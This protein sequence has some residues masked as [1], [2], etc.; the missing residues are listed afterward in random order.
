MARADGHGK[1]VCDPSASR[2]IYAKRAYLG[3]FD[4][5]ETHLYKNG[6]IPYDTRPAHWIRGVGSTGV[7]IYGFF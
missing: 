4:M 3:D 1:P 6:H 7:Y 5:V 2:Q